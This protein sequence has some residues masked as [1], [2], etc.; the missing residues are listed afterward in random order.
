MRHVA[1]EIELTFLFLCRRGQRNDA[2]HTGADAL[3]DGF[4]RSAFTC[5]VA[6]FKHHA[7]F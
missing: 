1:L 3:G 6:A 5:T 4:N 7:D 2:K